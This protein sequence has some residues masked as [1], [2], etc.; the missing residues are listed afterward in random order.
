MPIKYLDWIQVTAQDGPKPPKRHRRSQMAPN[1]WLLRS[2]ARPI[3][4]L[5]LGRAGGM[6]TWGH[7]AARVPSTLVPADTPFPKGNLGGRAKLRCIFIFCVFRTLKSLRIS[8]IVPR[9]GGTPVRAL[10]IVILV[11]LGIGFGGTQYCYFSIR[12]RL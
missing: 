5:V 3:A 7:T 2:L 6:R 1:C 8:W 4:R 10:S 9:I 11:S 12:G